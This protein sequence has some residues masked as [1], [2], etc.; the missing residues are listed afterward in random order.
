MQVVGAI[1][2]P[3]N[4]TNIFGQTPVL[5]HLG[6]AMQNPV[7]N[8]SVA[9]LGMAEGNWQSQIYEAFLGAKNGILSQV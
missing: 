3:V 8:G 9:G 2:S 1:A 6:R 5:N 4:H 7:I